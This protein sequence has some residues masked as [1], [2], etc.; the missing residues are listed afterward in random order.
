MGASEIRGYFFF[1]GGGGVP[2]IRAVYY[3]GY[4]IGTPQFLEIPILVGFRATGV[5][6][7]RAVGLGFVGGLQ[8][9]RPPKQSSLM[10]SSISG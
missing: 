6:R 8:G 4:I 9:L 2:R 5:L 7:S 10:F 1:W 3:F